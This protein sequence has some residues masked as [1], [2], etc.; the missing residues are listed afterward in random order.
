LPIS[1]NSAGSCSGAEWQW[2]GLMCKHQPLVHVLLE[3]PLAQESLNIGA[4]EFGSTA[5]TQGAKAVARV[6]LIISLS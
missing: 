3:T 5:S 2:A 6:H 1:Q 4:E